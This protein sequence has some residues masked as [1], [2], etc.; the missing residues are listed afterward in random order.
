MFVIKVTLSLEERYT[1]N[2]AI[3]ELMTLSNVLKVSIL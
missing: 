2:V 3:A 1:F